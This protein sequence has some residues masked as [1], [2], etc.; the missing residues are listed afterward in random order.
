MSERGKENRQLMQAATCP[1]ADIV[2]QRVGCEHRDRVNIRKAICFSTCLWQPPDIINALLVQILSVFIR[3]RWRKMA[4]H[5]V[6]EPYKRPVLT[7]LNN[8]KLIFPHYFHPIYRQQCA[9]GVEGGMQDWFEVL[10]VLSHW[11]FIFK[12]CFL[13]FLRIFFYWHICSWV[14]IFFSN[15]CIDCYESLQIG[16][17]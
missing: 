15:Y 17:L 11:V 5:I 2:L 16:T 13:W 14:S 3:Q 9:R 6:Q 8:E 7:S 12:N 4:P 10:C 1:Q